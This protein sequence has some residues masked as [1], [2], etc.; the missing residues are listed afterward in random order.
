M[1]FDE[2]SDLELRIFE[3]IKEHDFEHKKWRSAQAASDLGVSEEEVYQAL[4]NMSKVIRDN[5]WIHY[6]DGG[7]R[8]S[9]EDEY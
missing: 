5:I 9:V 7:I 3:Y 4:S 6:K 1:S 2:L 8:I